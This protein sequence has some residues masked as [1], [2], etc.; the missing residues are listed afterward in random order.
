MKTKYWNLLSL[1]LT[2]TSMKMK[3]KTKTRRETK[4]KTNCEKRWW[5]ISHSSHICYLCCC[6]YLLS[7]YRRHISKKTKMKNIFTRNQSTT[8]RRPTRLQFFKFQAN[9][10]KEMFLI[11][12]S[13]TIIINDKSIV[14]IMKSVADQ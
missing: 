4:I 2:K 12:N 13:C 11:E 8:K 14:I 3:M 6:N 10:F 7:L 1:M 9:I 5:L